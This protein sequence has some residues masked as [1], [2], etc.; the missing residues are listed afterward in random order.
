MNKME[1]DPTIGMIAAVNKDGVFRV[2]NK[3]LGFTV[4]TSKPTP[5][6]K[7]F[8]VMLKKQV[9]EQPKAY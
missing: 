7:R 5:G 3:A 6:F 2:I 9:N 4:D 1:S 8:Y